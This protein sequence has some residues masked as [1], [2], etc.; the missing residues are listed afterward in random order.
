V[1]D[2][3]ALVLPVAA[4]LIMIGALVW[5]QRYYAKKWRKPSSETWMKAREKKQRDEFQRRVKRRVAVSLERD[6]LE[7]EG[8]HRYPLVDREPR[9][10]YECG[11]CL[12]AWV[13]A[14]TKAGR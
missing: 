10:S 14:E 11:E 9:E 2:R 8:G 3:L 1:S 7:L 5:Q 6:E 4:M 12:D 13:K